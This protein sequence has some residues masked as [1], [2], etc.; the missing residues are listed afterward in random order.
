MLL[1]IAAEA[2]AQRRACEPLPVLVSMFPPYQ[3]RDWAD[4]LRDAIVGDYIQTL[5]TFDRERLVHLHAIFAHRAGLII[6]NPP[7]GISAP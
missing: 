1:A 6:P 3:C 5:H 7:V 2:Q 4:V